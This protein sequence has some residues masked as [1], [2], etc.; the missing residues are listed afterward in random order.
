MS[1]PQA[2]PQELSP[3]LQELKRRFIVP[4]DAIVDL[5]K[6][7]QRAGIFDYF[8][9]PYAPC[10]SQCV[11]IFTFRDLMGHLLKVHEHRA[12][13]IKKLVNKGLPKVPMRQI[14]G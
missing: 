4:D 2:Q 7:R 5:V 6:P 9:C 12:Q 10:C 14:N 8:Y 13:R 1:E 3:A 11:G